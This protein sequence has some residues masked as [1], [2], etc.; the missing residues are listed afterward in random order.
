[1]SI[2]FTAPDWETNPVP[3]RSGHPILFPFPGRMREGKFTFEGK[4][5]QLPLNDSTKQHA[6]HGF[7]PRNPWRV[8]DWNRDR[9]LPVVTGHFRLS[10]DLPPGA[11]TWPA[12]FAL[13]ITYRLQRDLLRVTARI[14]NRSP[15]PLPFGLGYHPYFRLPGVS[16]PDI[17]G[18]L[19][20]ANV[21]QLWEAENN[22]P[23]GWRPD[24]PGELDFR[25]PRP[26]GAI[27]LDHVFTNVTAKPTGL[28]DLVEL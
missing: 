7:T 6:I 16:D 20:Q 21:D 17:G 26:I 3:T 5:Y 22:L 12:D 15:T 11:G 2:L 19:L 14:E 1:G 23:T 8:T 24:V 10:Q 28:S 13:D 27:A 4:T 9:E 18:Y 25:Q